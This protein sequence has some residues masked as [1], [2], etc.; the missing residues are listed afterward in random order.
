MTSQH[1]K[2]SLL[3]NDTIFSAVGRD[4]LP[5]IDELRGSKPL[6]SRFTIKCEQSFIKKPWKRLHVNDSGNEQLLKHLHNGMKH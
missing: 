4:G 2:D 6:T 5:M 1:L 3:G